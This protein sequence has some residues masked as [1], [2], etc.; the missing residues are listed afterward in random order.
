MNC[1]LYRAVIRWISAVATT[2]PATSVE[3]RAGWPQHAAGR[4][5]L[6]TPKARNPNTTSAGRCRTSHHVHREEWYHVCSHRGVQQE[7]RPDHHGPDCCG[8]CWP[9]RNCLRVAQRDYDGPGGFAHNYI[10]ALPR[11]GV[12]G[13]PPKH[14]PGCS[15]ATT[16]TAAGPRKARPHS[17]EKRPRRP[18]AQRTARRPAIRMLPEPG[19]SD[20]LARNA[21]ESAP[22]RGA[23]Q[24]AMAC[25]VG[26]GVN[27]PRSCAVRP[28]RCPW[29]TAGATAPVGH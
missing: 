23:Q 26:P 11:P 5:S 22:P 10:E 14:T 3:E 13:E 8:R 25:V 24:S 19:L 9:G 15:T 4:L 20:A 12:C 6:R 1:E 17:I 28:R 27:K 29:G 2:S 7:G 18:L 16:A 21:S